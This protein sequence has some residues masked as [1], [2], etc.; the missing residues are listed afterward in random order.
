MRSAAAGLFA[1]P[2]FAQLELTRG[3]PLVKSLLAVAEDSDNPPDTRIAFALVAHERGG[4]STQ[5]SARRVMLD[6]MNSSR[7]ALRSRGALAL[8]QIGDIET[9][10]GELES[11]SQLPGSDGRLAGAFLKNELLKTYYESRLRA[12]RESLTEG[13]DDEA[14]ARGLERVQRMMD[15]IQHT[16]IEGDVHDQEDLLDAALDG[17]LGSL[18]QH[19]SY[20]NPAAY[21]K[22]Q[23][24]LSG[25]YGGIGAYVAVDP[26]DSLFTITQPIYSG[27]AYKADLRTDDKIVQ[28][29]IWPTHDH[30]ISK[31]QNEIIRRL[32]GEPGTDIKLYIWRRGMPT[33]LIDRPTEDMAVT[34]TRGF[35]TIPTVKSAMLPGQ[36]A[37]VELSQFSSVASKELRRALNEL[38]E[39]GAESIVLDLRSNP[40][41]LL[42]EARAVVDLFLAKGKRVV[43]TESRIAA[44]DNLDTRRRSVVPA[45]MPVVV[46]INRFS[47]SASEIV[48]GAL[49]DHGRATLV[50]QRSFGKGSVQNLM[51]MGADD[52]YRDEN[53]N[54][55][56][57]N[58]EELTVDRNKNGEFDFSGRAK[59]T[60]A[61][62]LLPSGRSIHRELDDEGNIESF[63]GVSPEFIVAPKRWEAWRL[64]EMFDL[65]SQGTVRAWTREK[66]AGHAEL[67]GRLAQD[68]A[69]DPDRYPGFDEFYDSLETALPREDV[70][71]MVRREVRRLVQD[72]RGA[73]FPRGDYEEDIQLQKAL[74]VA[75]SELGRDPYEIEAYR[76]TFDARESLTGGELIASAD[77]DP[78]SRQD[79]RTALGLIAEARRGD[80]KFSS[81]ALERLQKILSELDR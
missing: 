19:S 20:M 13:R 40:G 72:E 21:A 15:L 36:V 31:D 9:A 49:Q 80:G 25:E 6:F 32:K 34:I 78:A 26:G 68:D 57:D 81:E 58:W 73:S 74:Q 60:I 18:D 23:Q 53:H 22:F 52:Q 27:P 2:G 54:G 12:Q 45:D 69:K 75:L 7:P 28:I 55:K 71:F 33:E 8:A 44:P 48:S 39:A 42:S 79:V 5:R 70:R 29:G 77:T 16:H 50:G 3:E 24:E 37:L 38:L 65:Q 62:Y 47:A 51:R 76:R 59:L 4:G 41:G 10:R 67:F 56:H 46:L 30:G 11:L 17:M 63:G 66:F 64:E 1:D 14:P 43:T 61:R 35:I